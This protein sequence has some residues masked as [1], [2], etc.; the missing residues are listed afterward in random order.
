M[1]AAG[2]E[3]LKQVCCF[4]ILFLPW[5]K[6]NF[7]ARLAAEHVEKIAEKVG[8]TEVYKQVSSVSYVLL[9]WYLNVNESHL[10]FSQSMKTV[11]DEID[12]ITD[13]R[14]YSRPGKWFI[15]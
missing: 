10:D 2:A 6:C 7:Q 13:V 12:T 8:D 14:M 11:K 4:N 5:M 15:Q 3:A 1:T 9:Y